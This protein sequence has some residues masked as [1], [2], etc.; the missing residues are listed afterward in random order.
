MIFDDDDD[1]DDDA[2]TLQVK[3]LDKVRECEALEAV[4]E[5]YFVVLV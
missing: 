3:Y 2:A 4:M 1:D 5:W